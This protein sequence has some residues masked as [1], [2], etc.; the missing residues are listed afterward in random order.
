MNDEN[1]EEGI[2]VLVQDTL[3]QDLPHREIPLSSTMQSHPLPKRTRLV[4]V[5]GKHGYHQSVCQSHSVDASTEATTRGARESATRG[6]TRRG[7]SGRAKGE[8]GL[9]KLNTRLTA[10]QTR[11]VHALIQDPNVSV[12]SIYFLIFA[13]QYIS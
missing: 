5:H 4:L 3:S 2:R 9:E 7:A 11:Q 8:L 12:C 10:I 6:R 1:R 13:K